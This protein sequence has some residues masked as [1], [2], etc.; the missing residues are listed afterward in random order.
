MEEAANASDKSNVVA[1]CHAFDGRAFRSTIIEGRMA[2]VESMP[3]H[4]ATLLF[5]EAISS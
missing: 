1:V 5:S 4:P 2:A 3:P